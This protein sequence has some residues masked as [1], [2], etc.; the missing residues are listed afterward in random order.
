VI[1]PAA[2]L[3]KAQF[4]AL[5]N[6]T[7]IKTFFGVSAP[8]IY[9]RPP[10]DP[11]FPYVT[12]GDDQVIDD[13]AEG[14]DASEVFTRTH[15]WSKDVGVVEAKR[16]AALVANALDAEL[17]IEGHRVVEHAVESIQPGAASDPLISHRI[18]E[19]RY[20]TEP[21]S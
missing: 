2:P 14:L 16:L 20:L 3:Q 13:R 10:K 19:H 4:E 5:K 1:D 21:T 7:A 9:D 18:V 6:D 12:I 15:V 11:K 17:T 8:R